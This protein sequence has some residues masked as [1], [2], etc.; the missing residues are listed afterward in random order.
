L[1]EKAIQNTKEEEYIPSENNIDKNKEEKKPDKT[2]NIEDREGKDSDGKNIKKFAIPSGVVILLIAI[3][4]FVIGKSGFWQSSSQLLP[5]EIVTSL[6]PNE[7]DTEEVVDNLPEVEKEIFTEYRQ[8]LKGQEIKYYNPEEVF[9]ELLAEIDK[10]TVSNIPGSEADVRQFFNGSSN[11]IEWENSNYSGNNLVLNSEIN[12]GVKQE[13]YSENR[14]KIAEKLQLSKMGNYDSRILKRLR[15]TIEDSGPPFWEPNN[16]W[17]AFQKIFKSE[18]DKIILTDELNRKKE[19]YAIN[20]IPKGYSKGYILQHSGVILPVS[21]SKKI[22]ED[23]PT[24]IEINF[25]ASMNSLLKRDEN[26][27]RN[28]KELRILNLLELEDYR[29]FQLVSQFYA[30]K[31]LKYWENNDLDY[32]GLKSLY[33]TAWSNTKYSFNDVQNIKMLNDRNFELITDFKY[34]NKEGDTISQLSS[35]HYT[36]NEK[37]L[38]E[39]VYGV[40]SDYTFQDFR[41][42]DFDF[43]DQNEKIRRFL[44]AENNRKF[45]KIASFYSADMKRYWYVE[46][47]TFI[48]IKKIYEDAWGASSYSQNTLLNI[49]KSAYNTYDVKVRFTFHNNKANQP[50]TRERFTRY[51]FNEKG[52]IEE[53]YGLK[54]S[55]R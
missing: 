19:I 41:D 9:T 36:F 49:E 2:L 23:Y 13:P 21:F 47:P 18:F 24:A 35:T 4:L 11:P 7:E 51:I 53:V 1:I 45:N 37:G 34:L 8:T 5:D 52:L 40:D 29:D 50:E 15:F 39:E 43:I 26:L 31:V 16:K 32:Q 54:D 22:A 27:N 44:K 20:E 12:V 10:N 46:D 30:D 38:I 33:Q 6:N 14:N 28:E 17:K 25:L 42:S 55:R 48:Q 3:I